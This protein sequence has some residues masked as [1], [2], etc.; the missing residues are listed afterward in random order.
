[1]MV[2]IS[3]VQEE[4]IGSST[5]PFIQWDESIIPKSFGWDKEDERLKFF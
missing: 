1:M 5:I 2:K 4:L 3:T